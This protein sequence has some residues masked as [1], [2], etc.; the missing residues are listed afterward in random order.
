M[1]RAEKGVG[2][3]DSEK[4]N[5]AVQSFSTESCHVGIL[6]LRTA[7]CGPASGVRSVPHL[8]QCPSIAR[9]GTYYTTATS[10]WEIAQS[11]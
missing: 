6:V 7:S 2:D 9:D 10:G 3:H 1:R 5:L 8:S 11:S 4:V